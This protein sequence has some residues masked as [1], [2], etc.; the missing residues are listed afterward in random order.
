MRPLHFSLAIICFLITFNGFSQDEKKEKRFKI[1]TVAFYNLENFEWNIYLEYNEDLFKNNINTEKKAIIH[2]INHGIN[3]YRIINKEM[4]L[5][6]K[7]YDWFKYKKMYSTLNILNEWN[8]F[9]HYY[10]SV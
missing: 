10:L 2:F 5:L 9:F 3:E 8:A 7:N 6:W 1:H 4:V